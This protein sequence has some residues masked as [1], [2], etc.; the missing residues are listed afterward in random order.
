M[1]VLFQNR[2]DSF[3]ITGGDTVQMQKTM[4]HLAAR[5]VEG[6]IDLTLEPDLTDIDLVHVF[7]INTV[8][9]SYFQIRNAR[10]QGKPVVLSTV[11]TP[12]L[13]EWD[14]KGR[15][16]LSRHFFEHASEQTKERAKCLVRLLRPHGHQRRALV[17]Q[18]AV[19]YRR[20]VVGAL[21]AADMLLPNSQ[22][23]SETV[24]R[25]F[26]VQRPSR[27]VPN[28]VDPS[29][30]DVPRGRFE[31]EFGIRNYVLCV[32]N[33]YSVKNQ[34]A[35]ARAMAARPDI[36]V[37]FVGRKSENH[38][39]YYRA[40]VEFVRVQP[41]MRVLDFM[42]QEQLAYAY[43]DARVHVLPGW[44][45]TTGLASLEAGLAG[46]NVVTTDR[47]YTREY[48][49]DYAWYC[50][51]DSVESIRQATLEAYQA[52][53]RSGLKD[54]ILARFTWDRAADATLDAYRAVLENPQRDP[55]DRQA[56]CRKK[57]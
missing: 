1:R 55:T 9:P 12:N 7:N 3:A 4:E 2:P 24:A 23:E 22:M 20:Q 31:R 34:L 11:F 13:A 50:S 48:F 29:F 54:R 33:F 53:P 52:A 43:A 36:P 19:G 30:A 10:R 26:G 57:N 27:I 56:R 45:E 16:G 46:C 18:M 38:L 5:G 6:T 49:E 39:S 14:R 41:Q 47:G 25:V 37:V 40:F 35:L 51:P 28:G 32:A 17:H 8:H 42:P 44:S 15:Y 21:R